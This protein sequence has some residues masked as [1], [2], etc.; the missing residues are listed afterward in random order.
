[1]FRALESQTVC[2]IRLRDLARQSGRVQ[3][4][5]DRR[6]S[7]GFDEPFTLEVGEEVK[8]LF[9]NDEDFASYFGTVLEAD[10]LKIVFW[11]FIESVVRGVSRARR[12]TAPGLT[13]QLRDGSHSFDA[14]LCDVS[15]SG[16]R[17]K[18]LDE[19]ELGREL[20]LRMEYALAQIELR[21][22]VVRQSDSSDCDDREFGLEIL[23]ADRLSRARYHH[24]VDSLIRKSAVAA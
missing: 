1:M 22:R 11:M 4:V 21:V 3:E 5:T 9:G 17:L 10:Q 13:A 12:V 20:T 19:L 23:D 16:M 18:T 15:E 14:S 8:I 6:V 2:V 24:M 7:I